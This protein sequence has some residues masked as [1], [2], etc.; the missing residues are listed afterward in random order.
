MRE[1]LEYY[2]QYVRK[3]KPWIFVS[4]IKVSIL[5]SMVLLLVANNSNRFYI[6]NELPGYSEPESKYKY[7]RNT[8][9][10]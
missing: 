6:N 10:I 8:K 1:T 3:N 9:S 2:I 7:E 5:C 4:M